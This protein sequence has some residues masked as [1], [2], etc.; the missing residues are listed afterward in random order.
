MCKCVA[1]FTTSAI[2]ITNIYIV[3]IAMLERKGVHFILSVWY[4]T[5]NM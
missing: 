3:C 2:A 5:K 4:H 1:S